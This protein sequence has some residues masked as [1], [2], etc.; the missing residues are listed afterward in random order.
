MDGKLFHRPRIERNK[1]KTLEKELFAVGL[2]IVLGYIPG[3]L[4]HWFDKFWW[5]DI[6]L[7]FA[8]GAWVALAAYAFIPPL[9]R[10]S[11]RRKLIT[12]L[13]LAAF[14]V[15]IGW[16]IFE[17]AIEKYYSVNFQGPP[18]DTLSDLI[19]DVLG[20]AAGALY[21]AKSRD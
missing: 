11:G 10:V 16:E 17:F 14:A 5:L 18:L 21:I 12:L 9:K 19:F 1:P 8:G 15:G 6:V 7:H 3:A 4:Y 13:T 20:G 2:I